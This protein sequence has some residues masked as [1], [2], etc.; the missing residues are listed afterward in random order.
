[1]RLLCGLSAPDAPLPRELSVLENL[2]FVAQVRGLAASRESLLEHL[3]ACGLAN[4]ASDLAGDLSS[5]LR[6]RLGL[7]IATVHSPTI[8]L[9]DE[10]G[11]NLDEAGRQITQRVLETQRQRGITLLATNDERE[12]QWCDTRIEL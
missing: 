8:L 5:G 10:P 3:G 12:A 11:A 2:E 7:A 6:A 1:M 9:L 4:R